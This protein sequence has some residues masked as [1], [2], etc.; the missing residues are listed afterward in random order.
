MDVQPPDGAYSFLYHAGMRYTGSFRSGLREGIWRVANADGS[1]AWEV[2]W[3]A[4]KWHGSATTWWKNGVK[5]HE[6]QYDQGK[7]TGDWSFWF[8]NG[9]LAAKG[10][11]HQDRK[12]GEWAYWDQAGV[13]MGYPAW[14][15]AF[16]EWDW[17]YDDYSGFPRGSNWP[18]PPAD[19]V[20][21]QET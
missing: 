19:V 3:S 16:H 15:R 1:K 13:Q 6:G 14:E 20:P 4:G 21:T 10:Q 5:Q 7:M 12:V 11:Y 18:F 9:Q 2:S 17:A 8:D